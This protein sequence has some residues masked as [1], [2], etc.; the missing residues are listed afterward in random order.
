MWKTCAIPTKIN[1]NPKVVLPEGNSVYAMIRNT[2]TLNGE[3]KGNNS[4]NILKAE[5]CTEIC[6]RF[7]NLIVPPASLSATRVIW[8]SQPFYFIVKQPSRSLA[9]LKRRLINRN[10]PHFMPNGHKQHCRPQRAL[11][12]LFSLIISFKEKK[13]LSWYF[14]NSPVVRNIVPSYQVMGRNGFS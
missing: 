13:K 3:I 12:V 14:P 8:F 5:I 6:D 4:N 2:R 11:S 10:Q 9:L 1:W 7:I